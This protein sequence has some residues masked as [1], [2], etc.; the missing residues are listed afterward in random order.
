[1]ADET[2]VTVGQLVT[3]LENIKTWCGVVRD[4]LATLPEDQKIVVPQDAHDR[5]LANPPNSVGGCKPN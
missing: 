1:M 3:A 4:A 2:V 5:I